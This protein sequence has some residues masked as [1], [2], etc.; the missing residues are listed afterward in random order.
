MRV[1]NWALAGLLLAGLNCVALMDGDHP[2]RAG[3]TTVTGKA[4]LTDI[5]C[6]DDNPCTTETCPAD[7]LICEYLAQGDG[8]APDAAQTPADCKSVQCVAGKPVASD[9]PQDFF[10]DQ[11][12][13][14]EDTCT[15]GAPT[16]TMLADGSA[17]MQGDKSGTCTGGMCAVSCVTNNDCSDGNPCSEDLCNT[18]AGQCVYTNLDGVPTPGFTQITGDCKIQICIGG[19]DSSVND[20]ADVKDDANS[21]TTDIC[22][23]GAGSNPAVGSGTPCI[24]G[25]IKVCDGAGAC[26]ECVVPTDCVSITETECEKRSCV[27]N[28]CV[29]AYEGQTTLASPVLQTAKDCKKVVCNGANG[30][31]SINDDADLPDDANPCTTDTCSN[32]SPTFVNKAQGTSCGATS[33]CNAMGGC[34][35]CN[36]ANDCAGTDDFCKAR[37]CISNVCGIGYTPNGTDL[38]MANQIAGDCKVLQCNGTGG[39]KTVA[40]TSDVPVDGND[41]TQDMCNAQGTPS[42]PNSPLNATCASNGG[43]VCNGSGVCKKSNGK[44]CAMT[45]ECLTNLC[46][47]GVCCNTSCTTVCQAC[48]VAGKLGQCSDVPVG[49]QDG[50]CVAPTSVCNTAHNCDLVNGQTCFANGAC[51]SGFCVDNVCCNSGCDTACKS[52]NVAGSV[53]TCSNLPAGSTDTSPTLLCFVGSTC[54]GMGNCRQ[55][56]GAACMNDNQCN[57]LHCVDAVCCDKACQSTCY[58]CNVAGDQGFC[59]ALPLYTDDTNATTTCT[60][61]NTC[62]GLGSCKLKNGELCANNAACASNKCIGGTCQL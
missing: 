21:C 56:D 6:N 22:T 3:D 28:K 23:A 15:G 32:G 16:N 35:G 31:T 42:N 19:T 27:N 53:G 38:P 44:T 59:N 36:T 25:D 11:N 54:D 41:C 46:V 62:D 34:V 52:C 58:G 4:C 14:T 9:D 45:S 8:V 18:S 50:T 39:I 12:G 57:N 24:L 2:Y 47:D 60:G 37:T 48:N 61:T 55:P 7:T 17:C 10:N 49:T 13:C 20:D 5:N 29:I 43:D 51:F 33:V 30:T 40:R 1:R 26:V